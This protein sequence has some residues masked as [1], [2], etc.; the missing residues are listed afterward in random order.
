MVGVWGWSESQHVYTSSTK[1]QKQTVCNMTRNKTTYSQK[2]PNDQPL[3]TTILSQSQ[4]FPSVL[5]LLKKQ[6]RKKEKKKK[7]SC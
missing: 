2:P 3:I 7:K 1:E 4:I 6:Q 5:Y